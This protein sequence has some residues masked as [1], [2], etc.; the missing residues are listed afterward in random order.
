MPPSSMDG[1]LNLIPKANKDARFVENLRPLTLLNT[2]YK[3]IEK[4]IANRMK[5]SME[6]IIHTD[7][8]GFMPG[9]QI[10]ANIR[11]IFDLIYY[12]ENFNIDAII[13]SLDYKKC[14]DM[15]SFDSIIKSLHFLKFSDWIIKW[16]EILYTDYQV[17]AQ[18]NGN[19]SLPISIER[20]VHQG[21]VNSVNLFCV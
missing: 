10:L 9:R 1:I 11:K 18:N 16:T 7:Q 2:D 17:R 13:L 12:T 15:I 3:I 5:D 19:F 20:S 4:I 21:G 8:K 14:F 6:K